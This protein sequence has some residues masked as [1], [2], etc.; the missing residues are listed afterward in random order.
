MLIWTA[1]Q[2]NSGLLTAFLYTRFIQE[3][4]G[5]MG[6]TLLAGR[7]RK[8]PLRLRVPVAAIY[9]LS[10]VSKLLNPD[11]TGLP[12]FTSREEFMCVISPLIGWIFGD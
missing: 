1:I 2:E 8:A 10:S 6:G 9:P 4:K 11:R 5:E 7:G 3:I 12:V